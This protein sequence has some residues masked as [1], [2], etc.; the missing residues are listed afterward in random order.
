MYKFDTGVGPYRYTF[1][2][3]VTPVFIEIQ[4]IGVTNLNTSLKKKLNSDSLSS[5]YLC[6][7]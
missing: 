3:K 6:N 1:S 2:C 7:S 5:D 4:K